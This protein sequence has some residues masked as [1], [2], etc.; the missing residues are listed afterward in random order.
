M[1]PERNLGAAKPSSAKSATNLGP[2]QAMKMGM[3]FSEEAFGLRLHGKAATAVRRASFTVLDPPMR[4]Y[5]TRVRVVVVGL[6]TGPRPV[7]TVTSVSLSPSILKEETFAFPA[8][9]TPG[10]FA[11]AA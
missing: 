10:F 7:L 6:P 8:A 1:K 5:S 4:T 9:I 2:T 3:A 11:T